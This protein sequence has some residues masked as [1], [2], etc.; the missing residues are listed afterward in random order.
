MSPC[1]W[2]TSVRACV[3]V[4]VCMR[5]R[6]DAKRCPRCVCVCVC[7]CVCCFFVFGSTCMCPSVPLICVLVY[8]STCKSV[9]L[10]RAHA[11]G[12]RL[13]FLIDLLSLSPIFDGERT[14]GHLISFQISYFFL[15][16]IVEQTSVHPLRRQPLQ[17]FWSFWR[18]SRKIM[19]FI[20]PEQFHN[21]ITNTVRTNL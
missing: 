8:I 3:H 6:A 20:S 5:F 14:V 1:A 17:T 9:T 19:N 18:N 15:Q 13:C 4:C 16:G 12:S 10:I 11:Y 2:Y 7:V 21:S